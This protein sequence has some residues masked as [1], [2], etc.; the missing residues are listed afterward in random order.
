MTLDRNEI[1]RIAWSVHTH[2]ILGSLCIPDA[3]LGSVD[4]GNW[5]F[6]DLDIPVVARAAWWKERG[7]VRSPD[8]FY[9]YYYALGYLMRAKCIAEIGTWWSYALMAMATGA[10]YATGRYPEIWGFDNESYP[11]AENCLQWA[12]DRFTELGITHHMIHCDSRDYDVTG[13]PVPPDSVDIF[14]IDGDHSY[15]SA[16]RDTVLAGPCVRNGG[17]M[18]HDDV[19]WALNIR[20]AVDDFTDDNP[21]WSYDPHTDILPTLKGSL[22]VTRND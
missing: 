19:G 9:P 17:I 15:Q 13:L 18:I 1:E 20:D 16:F 6:P 14:S 5:A 12:R 10:K 7:L 22:I 11:G 21:N 4:Y 2:E 3:R 8:E